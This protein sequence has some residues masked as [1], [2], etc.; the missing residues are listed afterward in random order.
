MAR[1]SLKLDKPDLKRVIGPALAD[2]PQDMGREIII[3]LQA[4]ESTVRVDTGEMKASFGYGVSKRGTVFLTNSTGY[5][6]RVENR[7]GD[8]VDTLRAAAPRIRAKLDELLRLD[9]RLNG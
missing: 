2:L 7:F 6:Q 3:A 4:P 8:V 5:A 9:R 1:L